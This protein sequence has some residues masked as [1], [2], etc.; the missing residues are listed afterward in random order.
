[1]WSLIAGGVNYM[2]CHENGRENVQKKKEVLL[3]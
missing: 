2:L 1:M 3:W